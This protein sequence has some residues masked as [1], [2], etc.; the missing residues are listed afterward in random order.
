MSRMPTAVVY[1]VSIGSVV[2]NINS[3]YNYAP[4]FAHPI[5]PDIDTVCPFHWLELKNISMCSS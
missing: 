4:S 1:T 5:E 2:F 3:I